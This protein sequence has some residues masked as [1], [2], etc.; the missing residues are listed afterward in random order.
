MAEVH[1]YRF[2]DGPSHDASCR[3]ARGTTGLGFAF[4]DDRRS[5]APR[6]CKA[7]VAIRFCAGQE[8]Q[9]QI[10]RSEPDQAA[11]LPTSQR[12]TW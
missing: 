6:R 12:H 3:S 7:V 1:I 10:S 8:P 9:A 2:A 4:D 5:P 11:F